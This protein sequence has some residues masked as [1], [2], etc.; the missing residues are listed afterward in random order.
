MFRYCL[1]IHLRRSIRLCR[2]LLMTHDRAES[3]QFLLT[4]EFLGEMLGVR[5]S[6]VTEVLQPLQEDGLLRYHRGNITILDR[7]G[8]EAKTCEC[9]RSVKHTYNRLFG[10]SE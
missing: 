2:W 5:R 9:Y 1:R 8:L 10:L 4:H 6:S 3:D 7:K